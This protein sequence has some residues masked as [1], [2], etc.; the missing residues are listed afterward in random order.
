MKLNIPFDKK[1]IFETPVKDICSISL[2][3]EETKNPNELLGN[4]ILEGTYKEDELSINETPFHFVIP[5]SVDFTSPIVENSVEFAIEDFTYE[6]NNDELSLHIIY[7]VSGEERTI[8]EPLKEEITQVTIPEPPEE[9]IRQK[10]PIY[11][12]ILDDDY[13][14]YHIHIISENE[15]LDTIANKYNIDSRS[16]I[17]IN[18]NVEVIKGNKLIIPLNE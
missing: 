5:F 14:T 13:V 9:V 6:I 17:S 7:T 10:E 15:T 16:I 18:N 3:H 4:F 12:S 2:E 11:E 8:E 1:I